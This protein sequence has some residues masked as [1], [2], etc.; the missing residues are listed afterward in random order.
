M[1]SVIKDYVKSIEYLPP[2]DKSA[3]DLS[4]SVAV[5]VSDTVRSVRVDGRDLSGEPAST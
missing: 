3:W 5:R 2:S 4:F 1:E